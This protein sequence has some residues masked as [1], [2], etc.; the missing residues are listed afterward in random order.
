MKK[1]HLI[2]MI[3]RL[4]IMQI[5]ERIA[6]LVNFI[7]PEFSEYKNIKIENGYSKE[8]CDNIRGGLD[9]SHKFW[10][11]SKMLE[12]ASEKFWLLSEG[13]KFK[14]V[15]T[16]GLIVPCPLHLKNASMETWGQFLVR[17]AYLRNKLKRN[18]FLS[19]HTLKKMRFEAHKMEL[20]FA[21]IHQNDFQIIKQLEDCI[22]SISLKLDMEKKFRKKN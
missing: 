14:T 6:L 18:F 22:N 13:V 16:G 20:Q 11:D 3:G 2:Q 15:Y 17:V 19:K 4:L 12:L 10:F 7:R 9:L 1:P 21:N 5:F 8:V